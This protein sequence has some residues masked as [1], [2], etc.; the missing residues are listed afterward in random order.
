MRHPWLV[1]F[2]LPNLP[3]AFGDALAGAAFAFALDRHAGGPFV[4]ADAAAVCAAGAA[5]LLLY[6]AGLADNDLVGAATDD[7]AERPLPAGALSRR[8][9]SAARLALFLAAAA[10]GAAARLPAA[11]WG[12]VAALAAVALVYNRL[13]ERLPT[14]ALFLMGGCRALAFLSGVAALPAERACV[15]CG[16]LGLWIAPIPMA[17]W[18]L[19]IAA[20]TRLGQGEERASEPLG[21]WRYALGAPVFL[22]AACGAGTFFA[23]AFRAPFEARE[24]LDALPACAFGLLAA[25]NWC[26][27]VRPLGRPHAPAVRRRAV[28]R[29]IMGLLFLQSMA[30]VG[31][32]HPFFL[33]ACAL[34]WLAFFLI[35]RLAPAISGS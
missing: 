12:A 8:A 33:A 29:A 31:A 2:R 7:P 26:L 35:R 23:A 15:A 34:L 21:A 10:V 16:G 25:A 5:E 32:R 13:K 30:L 28:G 24:V 22:L 3:S 1:L 18:L 4:A 6:M 20:V 27:A 11:W 14:L 17:L 9:V 19:Y